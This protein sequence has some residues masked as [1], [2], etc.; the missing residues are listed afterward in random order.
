[1]EEV[2]RELQMTNIALAD[3]SAKVKSRNL[4]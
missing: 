3:L 1:V 2:E 4:A